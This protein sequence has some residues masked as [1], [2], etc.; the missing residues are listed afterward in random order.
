MAAKQALLDD[1]LCYFLDI[2]YLQKNH[3]VPI[4]DLIDPSHNLI[5]AVPPFPYSPEAYEREFRSVADGVSD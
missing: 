3:F 5:F 2:G 1:I 4:F